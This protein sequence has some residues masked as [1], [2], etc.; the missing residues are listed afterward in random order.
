MESFSSHINKVSKLAHTDNSIGVIY[1]PIKP[2]CEN[3]GIDYTRQFRNLYNDPVLKDYLRL[4]QFLNHRQKRM[5]LCLPDYLIYTWIFSI[6]SSSE[7]LLAFKKS[8]LMIPFRHYQLISSK[9]NIQTNREN[10]EKRLRDNNPDFVEYQ[11]IKAAEARIGK[12]MK[13]H[14]RQEIQSFIEQSLWL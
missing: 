4:K 2:I 13:S 14:E 10:S 3:L 8:F 7:K 12:A 11:N 5:M 6:R 9:A 1:F